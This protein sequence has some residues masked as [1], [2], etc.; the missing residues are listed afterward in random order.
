MR[1]SENSH[2]LLFN[3]CVVADVILAVAVIAFASGTVP[4]F[5]FRI[6]HI[7]SAAYGAAVVVWFGF[8][9]CVGDKWDRAGFLLGLPMPGPANFHAYRHREK[10]GKIAAGKQ[11]EICKSHKGEQI[12]RKQVVGEGHLD[13]AYKNNKKIND[14]HNPSLHRDNEQ[15][16]K[17]RVGIG[18]GKNEEQT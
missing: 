8:G 7:G 15:N 2:F 1:V 3:M 11:K 9:R 18:D 10:I 4:E 13:D 16:H 12:V 14:S 6:A 17:L 5:Q